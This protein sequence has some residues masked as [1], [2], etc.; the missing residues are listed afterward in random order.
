M[1]TRETLHVNIS[2][3]F[4]FLFW[5][6]SR[7]LL[8]LQS[9]SH[10]HIKFFDPISLIE[11]FGCSELAS[12]CNLSYFLISQTDDYVFRLEIG[13]D[14]VAHAM[15][16]VKSDQALTSKF[17]NQWNGYSLVV[18]TLDYFK[19]IDSQNLEDHDEVLAV[20]PVVDKR[21]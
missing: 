17:T 5:T 13:M 16:I 6:G 21:V 7:F 18:I 1:L 8:I 14:N 10:F 2:P 15:H 19:E 3:D 11:H 12:L 20:G 4:G 9:T